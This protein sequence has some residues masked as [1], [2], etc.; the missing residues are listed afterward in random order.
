MQTSCSQCTEQLEVQPVSIGELRHSHYTDLGFCL[1]V[2]SQL[3]SSKRTNKVPRQFQGNSKAMNITRWKSKAP[4]A[5]LCSL[6]FLSKP[7][8]LGGLDGSMPSA[9]SATSVS[10]DS[11]SHQNQAS[12]LGASL[13]AQ[14]GGAASEDG[15]PATNDLPSLPEASK[16]TKITIQ[17]KDNMGTVER[18]REMSEMF[19]IICSTYPTCTRRDLQSKS[20]VVKL[21]YYFE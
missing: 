6:D 4:Q 14:G 18:E 1:R 15:A 9:T 7:Q 2:K 3:C 20:L 11:A 17:G 16:V 19:P 10:C 21:L 5:Q 8:H 12:V 13:N